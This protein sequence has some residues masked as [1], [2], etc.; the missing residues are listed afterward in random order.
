MYELKSSSH[1]CLLCVRCVK[2]RKSRIKNQSHRLFH[3]L[4]LC[5][6]SFHL[7]PTVMFTSSGAICLYLVSRERG[8]QKL[9]S[10]VAPTMLPRRD[11]LRLAMRADYGRKT[12]GWNLCGPKSVIESQKRA[13]AWERIW[14]S[15]D[16]GG[17]SRYRRWGGWLRENT[18]ESI[19]RLTGTSSRTHR[20]SER[21]SRRA[22]S[23]ECPKQTPTRR[24][25]LPNKGRRGLVPTVRSSQ[26]AG[27]G[28][29]RGGERAEGAPDGTTL[30]V[31]V[32]SVRQ[33]PSDGKS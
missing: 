21:S 14:R 2:L 20:T 32:C 5:C 25:S 28:I 12:K 17:L 22:P 11:P 16:G 6:C 29:H 30:H 15:D 31:R 3:M 27:K 23:A 9:H 13:D 24:V 26:V 8:L 18:G 19:S 7:C 10:F 33:W 1:S 4:N